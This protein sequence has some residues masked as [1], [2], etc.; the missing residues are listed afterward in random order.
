MCVH[1]SLYYALASDSSINMGEILNISRQKAYYFGYGAQ[2]LNAAHTVNNFP[3]F[4]G[5]ISMK[6]AYTVNNS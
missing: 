6:I 1:E 2:K 3:G 4:R 5:K